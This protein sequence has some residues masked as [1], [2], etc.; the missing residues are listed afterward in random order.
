MPE[1]QPDPDMLE[2]EKQFAGNDEAKKLADLIKDRAAAEGD[3]ESGE[4]P[5]EEAEK[6]ARDVMD[7]IVPVM[8]QDRCLEEDDYRSLR[9][10]PELDAKALDKPSLR[11]T[12]GVS[13]AAGPV[14]S[15]RHP[16][17]YW[18]DATLGVSQADGTVVIYTLEQG[19]G[20]LVAVEKN[21]RIVAPAR[22]LRQGD[23][24]ELA[25]AVSAVV[26]SAEPPKWPKKKRSS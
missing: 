10:D 3:V 11:G 1:Q 15:Q 24:A 16:Y 8:A 4:I 14:P 22:P 6:L 19:K 13:V 23:L 18:N 25:D 20:P 17:D 21:D 26:D 12:R 2:F 9:L 5:A 7:R